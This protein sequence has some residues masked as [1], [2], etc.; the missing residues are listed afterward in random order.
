MTVDMVSSYVHFSWAL[1]SFSVVGYD[2]VAWETPLVLFLLAIFKGLGCFVPVLLVCGRW[3][4]ERALL[5]LQQ[6]LKPWLAR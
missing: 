1:G 4:P 6:P 3:S 5:M 2:S